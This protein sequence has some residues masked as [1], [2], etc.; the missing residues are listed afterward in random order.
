MV[1]RRGHRAAFLTAILIGFSGCSAGTET[2]R[3]AIDPQGVSKAASDPGRCESQANKP[4]PAQQL[5]GR[6][7]KDTASF[8]PEERKQALANLTGIPD[9]WARSYLWSLCMLDAQW[10]CP[11]SDGKPSPACRLP[12][13]GVSTDNPF[14]VS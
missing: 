7:D 11:T 10:Q 1:T 2:V 4:D 9:Q 8:T 6:F 14:P 13:A 5:R 3:E 12:S